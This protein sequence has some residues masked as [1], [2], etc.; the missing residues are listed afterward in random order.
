MNMGK[1]QTRGILKHVE[2]WHIWAAQFVYVKNAWLCHWTSKLTK[3][4]DEVMTSENYQKFRRK[5]NNQGKESNTFKASHSCG[6]GFTRLNF[7]RHWSSSYR[8]MC[9]IFRQLFSLFYMLL[10]LCTFCAHVLMHV[11]YISSMYTVYNCLH[12]N[13]ISCSVFFSSFY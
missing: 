5:K 11:V 2:D 10:I 12:L 13:C 3:W 1:C 8:F 9:G 6:N 4:C 7:R